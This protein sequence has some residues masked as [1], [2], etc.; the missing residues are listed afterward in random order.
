MRLRRTLTAAAL[1]VVAATGLSACQSKVGLAAS[2]G[3]Q[4][5]TDADLS[6]YVQPG[7]VPYT[8][9][10]T[11]STVVPKVYALQNWIQGKLFASAVAHKGGAA[12]SGELGRARTAELGNQTI[13]QAEAFY[14]RLGYTKK[15]ADLIV[16]QTAVLVVLVERIAP[17]ITPEQAI[18]ALQSGQAGAELVKAITAAK[19][20]VVV[21]SRYGSWDAKRVS[22]ASTAGV[23]APSF[24]RYGTGTASATAP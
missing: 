6:G 2:V 11:N 17:G 9:Q 21:S 13:G 22:L 24:I 5:L 8:D 18:S 20:K 19:T 1:A 16:D 10:N 12:T 23:G 15:F 7:T 3:A 4:R 14:D